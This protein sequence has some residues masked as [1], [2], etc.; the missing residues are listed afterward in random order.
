MPVSVRLLIVAA[1]F[2]LFFLVPISAAMVVPTPMQAVVMPLLMTPAVAI[3][4]PI[5]RQRPAWH[6]EHPD[7]DNCRENPR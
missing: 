2:I 5:A 4:I 3:M 1:A 7:A 6:R